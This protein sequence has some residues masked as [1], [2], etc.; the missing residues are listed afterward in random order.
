MVSLACSCSPFVHNPHCTKVR[1]GHGHIHFNDLEGF[2]GFE[3]YGLRPGSIA[4]ANDAAQFGELETLGELTK[5]AWKHDVQ[6]MI[7]GPGHRCR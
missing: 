5:T 3:G 6:T 1:L 7:E 2:L 4:D